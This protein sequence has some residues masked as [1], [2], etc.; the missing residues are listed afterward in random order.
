MAKQ[1]R[2]TCILCD[3]E[4]TKGGVSKHLTT[5]SKRLEA[6]ASA[7]GNKSE[8]LL[9]LR[10]QENYTKLFWLDIE[11]RGTAPLKDLDFYLRAIWL[12]CCGHMSAFYL[13]GKYEEEADMMMRAAKAFQAS[14]SLFYVYDFGSSSELTVT[15]VSSREGI[16]TTKK[17]LVLLARNSIPEAICATCEEPAKYLCGEC[18][19][20]EGQWA[21]FCLKC[22]KKHHHQDNYGY[23]T[24]VN[25]PRLGI[26]GYDGNALPPY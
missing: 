12:E 3:Y 15:L 25:S 5:C 17:P 19:A 11:M 10:V 21:A 7:T 4:S 6:Q 18:V 9:H 8:T 2:G 13:G 23:N 26:C 22:K 14:E 1:S 24:L 20:E 16:P